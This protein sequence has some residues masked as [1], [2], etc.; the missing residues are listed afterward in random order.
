[1]IRFLSRCLCS[2][3]LAGLLVVAPVL[4]QQPAPAPA[5]GTSAPP[6]SAPII[7]RSPPALQYAVAGLSTMLILV[8]VCMPSRKQ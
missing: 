3:L 1:M 2:L 4:G 8:I 6:A 7:E 5:P